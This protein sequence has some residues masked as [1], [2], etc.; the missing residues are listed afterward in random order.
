MT[1]TIVVDYGS[2]DRTRVPLEDF[3]DLGTITNVGYQYNPENPQLNGPVFHFEV[4]EGEYADA[5][6]KLRVQPD[7]DRVEMTWL[8]DNSTE[9]DVSTDVFSICHAIYNALCHTWDAQIFPAMLAAAVKA[10]TDAPGFLR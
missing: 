10:M 8:D 9:A 1:A 2:R 3:S 5:P 7:Y 4:C 6:R